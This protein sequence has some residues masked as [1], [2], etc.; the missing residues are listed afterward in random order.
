MART[1]R[2]RA[3]GL[4]V[5][6]L[7]IV[8]V[9]GVAGAKRAKGPS[10]VPIDYTKVKGLSQPI[11]E[12]MTTDVEMLP[13]ADG[14]EVYVEVIRPDAKGKFPVIA[15]ISPYH[16]TLYQRNGIRMLPNDGG[17]VPYFVPRG[18]AVLMM[19][20][21]GT[22]RSQGCLDHLGPNDQSDAKAV[23]EWA[24]KQPWS[25]GRVG[26]I[27][28][29]YPGGAS[30]MS[31]A[32]EPK[33]LVT[34]V[35][36]AGLGTMYEHQ[37]QAGVPYFLQWAGPQWAYN[38]LAIDRHLP[39]QLGSDP[40]QGGETGDNFGNDMEYFGCGLQHSA[41]TSGPSQVTGQYVQWHADRD[42]REG[43]AEN[44]VPVFV[45]HGVNDNAAR[46]AS[47]D[48]F[49]RG[50]RTSNDKLWL[51]QWN[52]GS[53]CCPNR[54]GL[55]WTSALHAWFDKQLQGR[56]V[57][58][59][60][61]VEA[62]LMDGSFA[63]VT[64][65][66]GFPKEIVTAKQWPAPAKMVRFF[67]DASGG[68]GVTRSA[69]GE[70]TFTGDPLGFNSPTDTDGAMF[71]TNP[72]KEDMVL[73]G[74]P[75]LKLAASVTAPHVHLIANLFDEHP[76]GTW[77]RISQFA[78]NPVLRNGIDTLEPVVPAERYMMNPPGYAM[79][80]RLRNGH[81]LVLRV[82]TSD[83]DKV[84]MFSI[85]PNVTVF[86]GPGGTVLQVPVI[87]NPVLYKDKFPLET[88]PA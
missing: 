48:W 23:I 15:E 65:G 16:G 41:L 88:P 71:A 47:L 80:H 17:L 32:E 78:I 70:A 61:P 81:K 73:L 59:G 30:V 5:V 39:P 53:G 29:S 52:H 2:P 77:R 3:L 66:Q 11:Y 72:L 35:V 31:L 67:P 21:R 63:Q 9:P 4:V 51:G 58:T 20:L 33:G 87:Q 46:V 19:D 50:T 6:L 86:T 68:L 55:Q 57:D 18:Y 76:D 38:L 43:A 28:H 42:F 37:F 54:R 14:V 45:I 75:K 84:P 79:A 12:E 13:M 27:G 40:V 44:D 34:A 22:G 56:K 26:V 25:N 8:A 60:P 1:L 62:F 74:V 64:V 85:D 69:A 7:L 82:T 36:S 24:A 49:S 83:P 10:L